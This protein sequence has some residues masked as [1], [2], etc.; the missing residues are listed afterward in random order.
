MGGKAD[1][2]GRLIVEELKPF[3]DATYRTKGD[4]KHT[5]LGGSSLGGL[6]SLYLGLK[7]PDVFGKIAAI[8]PSVWFADKQIVHYVE[9]LKT[10]PKLRIWLDTGTKEGGNPEEARYTVD[11]ARLLEKTL[12]KKGWKLGKDLSY[13]EARSGA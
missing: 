7:Y 4:A 1:R 5:G 3:I 2:Y 11:D 6:V 10:R 9:M 12:V 8:S 13:F